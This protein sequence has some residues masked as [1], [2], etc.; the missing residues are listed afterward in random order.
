[1]Y[2]PISLYH[3]RRI[4]LLDCARLAT[5]F[6]NLLREILILKHNKRLFLFQL[7]CQIL[8]RTSMQ[9]SSFQHVV[10]L[11]IPDLQTVDHFPILTA[12]IG[13]VIA[14]LREDMLLPGKLKETPLFI[15]KLL[16][17]RCFFLESGEIPEVTKAIISEPSFQINSLYFVLGNVK[18]TKIKNVKPFSFLNC[19]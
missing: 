1:M 11:D 15:E 19:K 2:L 16:N 8:N 14:L 13:I 17:S 9:T 3:L 5:F 12:V 18:N 7:L 4:S 6:P 10:L